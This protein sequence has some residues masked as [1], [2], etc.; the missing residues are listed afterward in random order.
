MSY[1][2]FYRISF[3]LIKIVYLNPITVIA[4]S[5]IDMTA[6]PNQCFIIGANRNGNIY[7]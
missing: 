2:V 3:F 4:L 5:T 7:K 6:L 1:K